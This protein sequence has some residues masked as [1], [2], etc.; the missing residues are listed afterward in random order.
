MQPLKHDRAAA[1]LEGRLRLMRI[2]WAGLLLA[3]GFY[4]LVA[5]LVDPPTDAE[6]RAA[7]EAAPALLLPLL[8]ILGAAVVLAS[9]VVKRAFARRAE[10]ERRPELLQTGLIVGAALCD[11]AALFGFVGLLVTGD[12]YA[13]LLFAVRAVG[14]LLH[15]PS[16]DRLLAAAPRGSG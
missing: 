3:V 14:I 2:V 12:R 7:G 4:A 5:Y 1:A 16:R 10:A 6:R 9:I 13:Y 8:V 15:F 11:A